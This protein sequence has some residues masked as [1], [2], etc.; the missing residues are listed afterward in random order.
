VKFIYF[1]LIFLTTL[2]IAGAVTSLV[3]KNT[4]AAPE[5]V[6][7]ILSGD[8]P[9]VGEIA[10]AAVFEGEHYSDKEGIKIYI[11]NSDSGISYEIT[12]D[13]NGLLYLQNLKEGVYELTKLH[14]E[15]K[16]TKY[17]LLYTFSLGLFF[18]LKKGKINNLG[19]IDWSY[20][21]EQRIK[22]SKDYFLSKGEFERRHDAKNGEWTDITMSEH[23]P[24]SAKRGGF[25]EGDW[26]IRALDTARGAGYMSAVEKDVV[27]EINKARSDPKKYAQ[28]YI[29]PR[30]EQYNGTLYSPPNELPLKTVEGV[31]AARECYNALLSA[32]AVEI[33]APSYGLSRAAKDHVQDQ[34]K[35]GAVGHSGSDGSDPFERIKRYGKN[36]TFAGENIAYK[37]HT[38]REIVVGLLID[39]GVPSRGHR[40]NIMHKN[41]NKIGVATGT[42]KQYGVMCV[43]EYAK[44]FEEN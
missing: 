37:P 21:K 1:L 8:T 22:H 12:S 44:D 11:R 36:Y 43:M 4:P 33:L 14:Y 39:D 30:L 18:E 9:L 42:H 13:K 10:F 16:T 41:Y 20:E 28:L 6:I 17:E 40:D 34:S 7:N 29:K 24:F 26:D 27:L 31:K 32:P 15:K 25:D 5:P 38:A 23:A 35:S 2:I 3:Q 19:A